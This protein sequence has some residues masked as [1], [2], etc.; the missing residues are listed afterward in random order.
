MVE[1]IHTICQDDTENRSQHNDNGQRNYR[2]IQ[3]RTGDENKK[4]IFIWTL[5]EEAVS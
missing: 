4:G 3:R 2:R 1:T 5:G